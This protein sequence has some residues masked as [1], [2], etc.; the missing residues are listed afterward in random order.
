MIN[1]KKILLLKI[2]INDH[3]LYIKSGYLG[4]IINPSG[5]FNVPN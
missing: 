4:F 2:I 1:I 5:D 3:F